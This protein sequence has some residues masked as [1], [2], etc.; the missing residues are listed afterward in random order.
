MHIP[1][2]S[3]RK[4]LLIVNKYLV[5]NRHI[6]VNKEY[7]FV[8]TPWIVTNVPDLGIS[9]GRDFLVRHLQRDVPDLGMSPRRDFLVR[10]LQRDVPN[11]GMSPR[12]DFLVRH[13]QRDVP[14]LGMSP[15]RDFLVRHLQWGR[16]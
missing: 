1:L 15:G 2:S 11:L 8:I 4:I 7:I 5:L 12:R 10:H 9:P 13:L 14:D 6:H 16:P 3:Q